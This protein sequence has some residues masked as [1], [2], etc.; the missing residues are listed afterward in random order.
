MFSDNIIVDVNLTDIPIVAFN[1]IDIINK[2]RRTGIILL[3]PY[4]K[5]YKESD[6]NNLY[7]YHSRKFCYYYQPLIYDIVYANI[8]ICIFDGMIY[9]N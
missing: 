8:I 7:G 1:T 5:P 2:N 3:Q 9:Q 6:L 4:Q